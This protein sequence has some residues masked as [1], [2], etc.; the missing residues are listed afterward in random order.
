MVYYKQYDSADDRYERHLVADVTA[1]STVISRLQPDT[2]YSF[3]I[4]CYNSDG[5]SPASNVVVDKTLGNTGLL[6]CLPRAVFT[7][8]NDPLLLLLFEL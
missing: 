3:Y 1:R 5:S 2:Q 7:A 6:P 8:E 4:D